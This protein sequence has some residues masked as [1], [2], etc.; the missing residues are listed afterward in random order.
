MSEENC[1]L[2]DEVSKKPKLGRLNRMIQETPNFS[3]FVSLGPLVTGHLLITTRNHYLSMATIPENYFPE[4]RQL[5]ENLGTRLTEAF[6]LPQ[7]VI[8][9][10]GPSK[11]DLKGGCC[12]DHAHFHILPARLPSTRIIRKIKENLG[13]PV[14]IESYRELTE[15]ADEETPYTFFEFDGIKYFFEVKKP[16]PSQFVRQVIGKYLGRE[17][18]WNWR[19]YPRVEDVIETIQRLKHGD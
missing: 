14:T 13:Q 18:T 7:T 1:Q 5:R 9:E 19:Q 15:L 12:L 4:L 2:C 17:Y 11:Y 6:H 16:I 8:F 10:H 3:A